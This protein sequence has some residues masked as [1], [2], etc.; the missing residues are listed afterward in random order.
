V[1][2]K[3]TQFVRPDGRRKTVWYDAPDDLNRRALVLHLSGIHFGI[4]ILPNQ[5]LFL[6][7]FRKGAEEPLCSRLCT[8]VRDDKVGV[9]EAVRK[10]VA[11][12]E[13]ILARSGG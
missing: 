11:D 12:A 10:L 8:A 1:S 2:I 9:L 4:E 3:F 5:T 7:C 13:S 6:M